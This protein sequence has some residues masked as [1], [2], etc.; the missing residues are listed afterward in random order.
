METRA[1][2]SDNSQYY[3]MRCPKCGWHGMSNETEGG[4]QIADTGDYS[5]IVCPA[6]IAPDGDYEHGQ[7]I[8]VVE[9]E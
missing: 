6:C 1:T 9:D 8:P 2:M 3:P 4:G 5:D 7:W